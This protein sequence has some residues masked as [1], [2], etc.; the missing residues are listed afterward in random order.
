[1]GAWHGPAKAAQHRLATG[2]VTSDTWLQAPINQPRRH[3][4]SSTSD[5]H[6]PKSMMHPALGA[7]FASALRTRRLPR[8]PAPATGRRV[9]SPPPSRLSP[10]PPRRFPPKHGGPPGR[11]APPPR[12]RDI[13]RRQ[14]EGG[15]HGPPPPPLPA[16]AVAA[17]AGRRAGRAGRAAARR[18]PPARRPHPAAS[19]RP[20]GWP[21]RRRRG[22]GV[23]GSGVPHPTGL[24]VAASAVL[25][26]GPPASGADLPC[27]GSLRGRQPP[28][29]PSSA[30][31]AP[32]RFVTGV[33]LRLSPFGPPCP[34]SFAIVPLITAFLPLPPPP[35][36]LLSP[37]PSP[38]LSY[39]PPVLLIPRRS[40]PPPPR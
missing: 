40:Q 13:P 25:A 28:P 7:P 24:R 26:R 23:T 8:F 21:W 14:H 11:L 29:S 27:V 19:P 1:M 17:A 6:S 5:C 35:P 36:P 3:P 32:C 4:K 22:W 2:V 12:P 16:T 31:H 10:P 18:R 9:S 33:A 37:P 39:P 38:C 15:G 30:R 20:R 34:S